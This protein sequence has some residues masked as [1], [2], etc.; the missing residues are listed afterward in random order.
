ARLH[1]IEASRARVVRVLHARGARRARSHVRGGVFWG[2][3]R[4]HLRS[5]EARSERSERACAEE[6]T[7]CQLRSH[8]QPHFPKSYWRPRVVRNRSTGT[9]PSDAGGSV[10][11]CGPTTY[12]A[13]SARATFALS[14][15]DRPG[16][17]GTPPEI[18]ARASSW[19]G[20]RSNA[21]SSEGR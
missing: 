11:R 16:T 9:S 19:G 20:A 15:Y 10:G 3:D 17:M 5:R 21:L 1:L 14:R 7:D 18:V 6:K 13:R 12:G 4:D 8:A 2:F